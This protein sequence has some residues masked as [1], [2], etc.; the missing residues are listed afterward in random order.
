MKVKLTQFCE[1]KKTAEKKRVNEKFKRKRAFYF[2]MK[3][4][5]NEEGFAD[6]LIIRIC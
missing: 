1:G 2:P 5:R 6:L 3:R 4:H